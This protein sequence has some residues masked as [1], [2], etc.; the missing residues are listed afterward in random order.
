MIAT[1]NSR[2]PDQSDDAAPPAVSPDPGAYPRQPKTTAT[3]Q[4]R[5]G[6]T[7]RL[8]AAFVVGIA[9]LGLAIGV[10]G[11]ARAAPMVDTDPASENTTVSSKL[12]ARYTSDGPVVWWWEYAT[13]AS[14]L[15]TVSDVEVC[16]Y[17]PEHDQ[18]C[19]PATSS[20]D[21]PLSTTVTRLTPD[22]TYYFRACAED[23]AQ[24]SSPTCDRTLSFKTLAGTSYTLE[25]QWGS[26][27]TGDGQ[28]DSPGDV[29]TDAF[30]NVRRAQR[31][32][33]RCLGQRLRQ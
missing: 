28:F 8:G 18:R 24:G 30:G 29:T 14:A 5:K 3:G 9:G 11:Q 21:V 10:A 13:A 27:G 17:P 4:R 6:T 26:Y 20:N 23:Q 2:Q 7:Q 1:S 16:G 25:R 31:R 19:G 33:D 12:N 22:T 15:G 32:H